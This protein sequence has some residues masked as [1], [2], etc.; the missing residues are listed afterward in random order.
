M[1]QKKKTPPSVT[2]IP[3][4]I[5]LKKQAWFERPNVLALLLAAIAALLYAV[6]YRNEWALDDIISITMNSF[7]QKGFAGIPDLLSKDSFY[8]FVGSASELT[9]GRWRPLAL[10]SFATEIEIFGWKNGGAEANLQLAHYMHFTN[11]MLYAAIGFLMFKV[12]A[13]FMICLDFAGLR[14]DGAV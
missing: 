5:T 6:T 10:L 8:G 13:R 12:I 2:E 11:I 14:S 9:G 3:Q 1:T 7:T 4:T